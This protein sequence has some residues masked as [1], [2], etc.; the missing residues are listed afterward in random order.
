MAGECWGGRFKSGVLFLKVM[1]TGLKLG[2]SVE[3]DQ[4]YEFARQVGFT[5]G[6][7]GGP[8]HASVKDLR[9]QIHHTLS[10]FKD[11]EGIFTD[12][13]FDDM[14]DRYPNNP[15]AIEVLKQLYQKMPDL[16][17]IKSEPMEESIEAGP[18]SELLDSL[19]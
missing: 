8:L 7:F 5:K 15:E 11:I 10:Y 17:Y 13:E 12:M 1:T 18:I 16:K 4:V 2:T 19:E 9:L 6:H 3:I 14:T